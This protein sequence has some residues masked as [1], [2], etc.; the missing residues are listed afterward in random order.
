M[1]F[2]KKNREIYALPWVKDEKMVVQSCN[3]ILTFSYFPD[4]DSSFVMTNGILSGF[5]YL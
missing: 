4:F 2:S 3:R 1:S 5:H